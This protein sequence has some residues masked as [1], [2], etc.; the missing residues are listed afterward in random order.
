MKA[1][2]ALFMAGISCLSMAAEQA[3]E[4]KEQLPVEIYEYSTHPDIA[5]VISR[6]EAPDVCGPATVHMT[7][8]D[9]Q[10]K[11]HVM[12]YLIMGNGCSGG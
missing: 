10:G 7:Y 6:S 12:E 9:H 2:L 3:D 5:K 11:R 8:E 1:L 4:N